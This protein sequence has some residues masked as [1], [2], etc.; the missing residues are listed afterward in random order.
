MLESVVIIFAS[1]ALALAGP[2]ITYA[3]SSS[4]PCTSTCS[5]TLCAD[6]INS[7]GQTYGG[8]YLACSG[9]TTPSFADPGCPPT[10]KPVPPTTTPSLPVD[11]VTPSTSCTKTTN[12]PDTP[13]DPV[14][15]PASCAT[16]ITQTFC[17]P[18][19]PYTTDNQTQCP[20]TVT[21][22]SCS[23]ADPTDP[24][25]PSSITTGT[26]TS[27]C[28]ITLCVD[29]VNSCGQTY[30][31]CFPA[32]PGLPTPIFTDP[33]CPTTSCTSSV[34]SSNNPCEFVCLDYFDQCGNTYG[35][36][37]WTSCP[38]STTPTYTTPYCS[39]SATA[40]A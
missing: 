17:P 4:T 24:P 25:P 21:P 29:N 36:G 26:S 32:C 13:V 1:L 33:G 3:P 2:T 18:P 30:G 11:P 35:P 6:Y 27:S 20:V 8:C 38:G 22:S 5:S 7:C 19:L 9:Y 28:T 23:T 16:T 40:T 31:G 10:T 37:C 39:V 14:T 34:T 12:T 15:P